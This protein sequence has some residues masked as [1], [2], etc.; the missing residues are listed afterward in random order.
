[1]KTFNNFLFI[2]RQERHFLRWIC[3]AL[4]I[5]LLDQLSKTLILHYN[6]QPAIAITSFFNIT[7]IFNRGAAFSFLSSASGWQ[8]L[9]F[10]CVTFL[11]SMT[12]V[13]WLYQ[14]TEKRTYLQLSL[15]LILGGA[16]GNLVDRLTRGNVIDFLDFYFKNWHWPAFNLAD[17]AIVIGVCLMLIDMIKRK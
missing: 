15:S 4:L 3:L 1:M 8:N 13:R 5:T 14:I 10:S 6:P 11:I 7:L 2:D 9:F 16:L 12:I 17:S